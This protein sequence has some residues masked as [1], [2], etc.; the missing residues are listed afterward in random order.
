VGKNVW[1]EKLSLFYLWQIY[2]FPSLNGQKGKG[3]PLPA[4]RGGGKLRQKR[5]F[6]LI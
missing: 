5:E 3:V 6:G 4:D 2:V 1:Q